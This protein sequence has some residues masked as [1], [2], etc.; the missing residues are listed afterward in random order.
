MPASSYLSGTNKLRTFAS[1]LVG[2]F[3]TFGKEAAKVQTFFHLRKGR[4]EDSVAMGFHGIRHF[5][6][7]GD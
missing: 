1:G 2:H 4:G 7:F 3:A 6:E 5:D